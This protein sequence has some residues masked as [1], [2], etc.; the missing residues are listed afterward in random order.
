M[1][2]S[3]Y[4]YAIPRPMSG[5]TFRHMLMPHTYTLWI[6]QALLPSQGG[7]PVPI[8]AILL[9]DPQR[10][11]DGKVRF[12]PPYTDTY[13]CI[14][15]VVDKKVSIE[16]LPVLFLHFHISIF[17]CGRRAWL[18]VWF[19]RIH[20]VKEC[21]GKFFTGSQT[22]RTFDV[23]C[24][25]K[26][27]RFYAFAVNQV[28]T[29]RLTERQK[30][31]AP[32]GSFVV[33]DDHVRIVAVVP[34]DYECT[35]IIVIHNRRQDVQD[36][37]GWLAPPTAWWRRLEGLPYPVELLWSIFWCL[38][39]LFS[40]FAFFVFFHDGSRAESVTI[41]GEQ[42]VANTHLVIIGFNCSD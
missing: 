38:I 7:I 4:A 17:L 1:A 16:V 20:I 33:S 32:S 25:L 34:L 8:S 13:T 5:K 39:L 18:V 3:R 27:T 12:T 10:V 23:F 15:V 36:L 24:H 11:N 30:K 29:V 14:D 40:F 42:K 2:C 19:W 35:E 22:G 28:A 37:S 9:C 26:E 6:W 21:L 31:I 41:L